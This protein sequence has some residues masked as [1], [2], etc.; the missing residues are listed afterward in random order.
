MMPVMLP[1]RPLLPRSLPPRLLLL[2][3]ALQYDAMTTAIKMVER[4]GSSLPDLRKFASQDNS[5]LLPA[6]NRRAHLAQQ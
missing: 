4:V 3:T 2:L 6:C 1:P 5:C